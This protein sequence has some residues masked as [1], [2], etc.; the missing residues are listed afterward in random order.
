MTGQHA[1]VAHNAA[2]TM[3]PIAAAPAAVAAASAVIAAEVPEVVVFVEVVVAGANGT[4]GRF[5]SGGDF[6]TGAA[7]SIWGGVRHELD[8]KRPRPHALVN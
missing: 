4:V 8:T 2:A 6:P 5:R 3:V 1:L 7:D